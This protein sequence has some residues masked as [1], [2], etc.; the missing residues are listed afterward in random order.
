[1]GRL[2]RVSFPSYLQKW[3]FLKSRK[4][5]LWLVSLTDL[6]CYSM[7]FFLSFENS[8][9]LLSHSF[10]ESS[11]NALQGLS[12]H[13]L[14]WFNKLLL[15]VNFWEMIIGHLL[16]NNMSY[17]LKGFKEIG[18]STDEND[19]VAFI[20]GPFW[21][22]QHEGLPLF[23]FTSNFQPSTRFWFIWRVK[24]ENINFIHML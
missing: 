14:S 2:T 13:D 7:D 19:T 8:L 21:I 5:W 12:P 17:P 9:Y 18:I 16:K 1:M 22:K 23:Y 24:M 15:N 10:K 6:F 4:S 11:F 20:N 3:T